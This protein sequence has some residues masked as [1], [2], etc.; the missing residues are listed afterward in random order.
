MKLIL[1]WYLYTSNWNYICH[2]FL[3]PEL[4]Q[5][6]TAEEVHQVQGFPETLHNRS[7]ESNILIEK[8]ES[9]YYEYVTI[10]KLTQSSSVINFNQLQL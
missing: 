8:Y 10:Y 2:T 3:Y 6:Y 1:T 5:C 7:D 9:V 4:R